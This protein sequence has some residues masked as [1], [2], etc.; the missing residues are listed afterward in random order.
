MKPPFNHYN[1]KLG[2]IV[3]AP[4]VSDTAKPVP[5]VDCEEVN[6][7]REDAFV[8]RFETLLKD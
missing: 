5:E 7:K 2:P 1:A 4:M 6:H 3:E 8:A